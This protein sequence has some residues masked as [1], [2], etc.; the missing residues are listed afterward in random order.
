MP[1]SPPDVGLPEDWIV[2]APADGQIVYRLGAAEPLKI[3]DFTSDR[4]KN[5]PHAF[6]RALR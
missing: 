2:I 3:R 5:R 4:D 1:P 6:R